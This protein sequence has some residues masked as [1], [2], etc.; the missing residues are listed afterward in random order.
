MNSIIRMKCYLWQ[1]LDFSKFCDSGARIKFEH[2]WLKCSSDKIRISI[3]TV[4]EIKA[5]VGEKLKR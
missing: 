2:F 3:E 4:E 5:V 1:F